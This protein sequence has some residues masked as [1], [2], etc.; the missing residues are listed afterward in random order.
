MPAPLSQHSQPYN[1]RVPVL[2]AQ[3][4]LKEQWKQTK[5]NQASNDHN[6]PGM[7]VQGQWFFNQAN[8]NIVFHN[9]IETALLMAKSNP[10]TEC[11]Y[12]WLLKNIF[13]LCKGLEL[14]HKPLYCNNNDSSPQIH[15]IWGNPKCFL[16][17]SHLLIGGWAEER[18]S[19]YLTHSQPS[20]KALVSLPTEEKHIAWQAGCLQIHKPLV[21]IV[22]TLKCSLGTPG[23]CSPLWGK[24]HEIK[25]ILYYMKMLCVVSLTLFRMQ[26]D[27][28]QTPHEVYYYNRANENAEVRVLLASI[29]L[30]IKEMC[31]NVNQCN[32]FHRSCS[33]VQNSYF[34]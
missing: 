14:L 12:I 5:C 16:L 7:K 34:S 3:L 9:S 31:S 10:W 2:V 26:G 11:F 29:K 1:D 21:S 27:V 18:W 4:F 25:A 23:L 33:I 30:G 13:G 20:G 22:E 8:V 15:C 19:Y 6:S 32:Y 28:L 17:S 24:I